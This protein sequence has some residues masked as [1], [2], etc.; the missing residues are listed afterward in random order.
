M[1]PVSKVC[2]ITKIQEESGSGMVSDCPY[3]RNPATG[4]GSPRSYMAVPL[5][6]L[7]AIPGGITQN[8]L[9]PHVLSKP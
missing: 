6:M 8:T 4:Q 7:S 1:L 9:Q 5:E 2:S 3:C